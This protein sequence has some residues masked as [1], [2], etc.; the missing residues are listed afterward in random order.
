MECWLC[1]CPRK[2]ESEDDLSILRILPFIK[3]RATRLTTVFCLFLLPLQSSSGIFQW[4]EPERTNRRGLGAAWV[5]YVEISK[6]IDWG[7][8]FYDLEVGWSCMETAS[9]FWAE[10]VNTRLARLSLTRKSL[11]SLEINCK[12]CGSGDSKCMNGLCFNPSGYGVC[13]LCKRLICC[14][15]WRRKNML[16]LQLCFRESSEAW[17]GQYLAWNLLL[18]GSCCI[19]FV[20]SLLLVCSLT[21]EWNPYVPKFFP[22]NEEEECL[23]QE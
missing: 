22:Y 9:S 14:Y 16:K 3:T 21:A 1:S 18:S 7:I 5:R 4:P 13:H 6:W 19:S 23:V 10:V 12:G 8:N 15:Q 2:P 20:F 17:Q 11:I